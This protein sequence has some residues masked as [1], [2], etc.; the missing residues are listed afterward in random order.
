MVKHFVFH[1]NISTSLTFVNNTFQRITPPLYCLS[2]V[3]KL[4]EARTE[5]EVWPRKTPTGK[6]VDEY[7]NDIV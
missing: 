7:G 4:C 3:K 6:L 5:W 1:E 2:A